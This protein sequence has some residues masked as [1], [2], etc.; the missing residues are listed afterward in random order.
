MPTRCPHCRLVLAVLFLGC[1]PRAPAVITPG[2]RSEPVLRVGQQAY[3][4]L[5]NGDTTRVVW[6]PTDSAKVAVSADGVVR[7]RQISPMVV[8]CAQTVASL[9]SSRL[10][11]DL[12]EARE[13]VRSQGRTA[14][15]AFFDKKIDS[16]SAV[17]TSMQ[18]D[19]EPCVGVRIV[20]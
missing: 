14:E 7:A 8:I 19:F 5:A 13:Y 11:D 6:L 15:L 10:R 3:L 12:V 17:V 16:L 9:P 4:R 1:G 18:G 2:Q 20:E